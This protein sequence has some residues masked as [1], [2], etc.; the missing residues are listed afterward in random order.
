MLAEAGYPNGFD[1]PLYA[2]RERHQTEAMIGYLQAVGVKGNLNFLQYA[3]M[4]DQVRANKAGLVHQTWGSFSVNDVS[5]A[6]PVYFGFVDDDIARDPEI[7]DLLANGDNSV[8]PG[9]RKEA[10]K[11]AL[12]LIAERA[13]TI[14]LYSL[15]VYYAATA[16]V[17]FKAYPDE[18]PRFW[19]MTWK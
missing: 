5:A 18:M 16:D 14:P 15:P 13:Y 9:M 7:R 8:D 11:K 3:A 10:Y 1:L 17:V 2:Y 12:A 6:T 19:E 4:R